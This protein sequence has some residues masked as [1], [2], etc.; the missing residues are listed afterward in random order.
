MFKRK[1]STPERLV[2]RELLRRYE[3]IKPEDCEY[4]I[5]FA[6]DN[7]ECIIYGFAIG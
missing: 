6:M 1:Q 4:N 5:K 3:L 7:P 2:G